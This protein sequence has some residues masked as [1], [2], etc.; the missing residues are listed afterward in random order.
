MDTQKI[1]VKDWIAIAG[2][3]G[4]I[5]TSAAATYVTLTLG[6]YRQELAVAINRVEANERLD[7]TEH[8]DFV[9]H[10]E[11]KQLVVERLDRIE[12]KLDQVIWNR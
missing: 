4:A 8:P 3:V 11:I 2:F 10:E 9:T 1:T 7:A 5:V 12:Q 6:P